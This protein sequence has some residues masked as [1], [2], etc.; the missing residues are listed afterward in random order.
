MSKYNTHKNMLNFHEN[1]VKIKNKEPNR[2][3]NKTKFIS[4]KSERFKNIFICKNYISITLPSIK[5]VFA[6]KSEP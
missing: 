4:L 1:Y 3:K 5:K 6:T 2:E